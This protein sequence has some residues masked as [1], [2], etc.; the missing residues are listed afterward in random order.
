MV[1]A[2]LGAPHAAAAQDAE[3]VTTRAQQS[4]EHQQAED[5]Q[6]RTRKRSSD[7]RLFVSSG[8]FYSTGDYGRD[9][10]TDSY[11]V[12]ASVRLRNGPLRLS[13]SMPY[14]HIRGSR[15]IIGGE[16]GEIIDDEPEVGRDTRSGFGDL[17]LRARYR[18]EPR[19]W[20]G[21][22]LDLMGRVK[23]PTGSERK[24]LSTGETDYSLGA[25][26]SYDRGTIRPFLEVQYR[27]NG[28]RPDRDYRNTFATSIGASS[29]IAR[30][31][32]ASLSYDYARSRIPGRSGF[33]SIDGSLSTTLTRRLFLT[34]FGSVGLSRRA[35][36]FSLGAAVT[37]RIF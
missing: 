21:V 31:V 32:N 35:D 22:E 34:G 8:L 18:L 19:S 16:D 17:S 11:T 30:R 13:A 5:N 15:S 27:I 10:R 7:W 3:R 29:R 33:H 9:T 1:A 6:P 12:P 24:R 28:D 4:E 14:H 37:A 25:E 20:K 23:L 2:G 36:D 26:L